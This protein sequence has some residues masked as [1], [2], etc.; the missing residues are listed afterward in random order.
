MSGQRR[1]TTLQV[2]QRPGQPVAEEQRAAG[3]EGREVV[4]RTW[5]S[6]RERFTKRRTCC[7][8]QPSCYTPT[9][10]R[11]SLLPVSHM[12]LWA[13]KAFSTTTSNNDDRTED[14]GVSVCPPAQCTYSLIIFNKEIEDEM[15]SSTVPFSYER[16]SWRSAGQECVRTSFDLAASN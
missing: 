7:A 2:K 5:E 4:A 15:V 12:P 3:V 14:Q 8:G 9:V 11:P 13:T 6:R 10:S 16:R 1:G